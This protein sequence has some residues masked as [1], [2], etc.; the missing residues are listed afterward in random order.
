MH[1]PSSQAIDLMPELKAG[2]ELE[3]EIESTAAVNLGV[4][5]VTPLQP[6]F[7]LAEQ[8]ALADDLTEVAEIA[9]ILLLIQQV[10]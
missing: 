9:V 6:Y 1:L 10:A 4:G 7:Q 5:T 8:A 3:I 2:P